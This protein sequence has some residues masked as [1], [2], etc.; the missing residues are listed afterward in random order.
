MN[1]LILDKKI[2]SILRSIERVESHTPKDIEVFLKNID[3]QDIVTLN[4]TRIIQSC[5][6]IAMHII[7]DSN[8]ETPQTM[9]ESFDT[10]KKLTIIDKEIAVKLKKSIGF[11]NIAV[12]NYGELDLELTY[13]IAK[14][15]L[16]DFKV[17]I[18]QIND[19]V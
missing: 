3:A 12:H 8:A 16:N 19:Y 15:H 7:A 11:R 9:S 17:Y 1:K 14:Q 2:D 10:L 18:K 4:L 6:D 5:V 13:I